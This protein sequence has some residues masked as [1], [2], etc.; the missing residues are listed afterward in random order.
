MF[1]NFTSKFRT[2][3][4]FLICCFFSYLSHSQCPTIPSSPIVICDGAGFNFAD[5]DAFASSGSGD[6]NWYNASGSIYRFT[7]S[8]SRHLFCR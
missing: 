4:C 6:I 2:Y 7:A 5:L 8:N 3:L 1:I